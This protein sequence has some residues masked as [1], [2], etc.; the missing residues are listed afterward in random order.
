MVEDVDLPID[1]IGILHPE[2]VLVR[3]TAVDSELFAYRKTRR[4]H[5][6]QFTHDDRLGLDLEA[7]VVDMPTGRAGVRLGQR[8]VERSKRRKKLHVPGFDLDGRD[9]Q[10]LL[11]ELA[12]LLEVRYGHV[13]MHTRGVTHDGSP[14]SSTR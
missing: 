9:A 10:E 12:A 2:L 13:Y 11:V 14:F 5:A 8:Q 3:V 1:T 7:H 4:L 6:L